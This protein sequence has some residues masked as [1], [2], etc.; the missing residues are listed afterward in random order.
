[1]SRK[2]MEALDAMSARTTLA[3]ATVP[4]TDTPT[5]EQ[6]DRWTRQTAIE[7][8]LQHHKINGGMQTVPQLIDNAKQFHAYITGDSK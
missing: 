1:M 3:I 7:L 6:S 2:Q 5:V 8:A 4:T